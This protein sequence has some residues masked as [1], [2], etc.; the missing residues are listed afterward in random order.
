MTVRF[1]RARHL[2]GHA[3][4][5][6]NP[7]RTLPN[8]DVSRRLGAVDRLG[9]LEPV[10]GQT[11]VVPGVTLLPTPGETPGHLVVRVHSAGETLYVLGD[12]V[13]HA[14]EVTHPDWAPPRRDLTALRASRE[15]IFAAMAREQALAVTG[16]ERFPPWGRI[17]ASVGGYRWTSAPDDDEPSTTLA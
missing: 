16:H 8:S 14:C 3:D 7:D 2:I 12:L 4:W 9:L 1:P 15:R 10:H 13:H 5:E 11:E 17:A 6:D